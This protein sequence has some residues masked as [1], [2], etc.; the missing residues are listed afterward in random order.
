MKTENPCNPSPCGPNSRC[1]EVNGNG[2]CSCL[3][4]YQGSPP[5]CRPMCTV[6]SE[7]PSDR[8]CLNL[9]CIDPC[10]GPCGRN[11]QCKT[12]NHSPYCSCGPS[13]TGNPF[14]QCLPES[15]KLLSSFSYMKTQIKGYQEIYQ[16]LQKYFRSST[17]IK[18]KSRSLCT[19][20]LRT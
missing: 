14:T 20:T 13:F 3:P 19:F 4:E 7:C 18:F 12:I 5:S 16:V 1:R 8:A 6:S 10:P 11:T 15:R 17:R 2:V 9:K